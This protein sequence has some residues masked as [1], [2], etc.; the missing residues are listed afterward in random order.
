MSGITITDVKIVGLC[1]KCRKPEDEILKDIHGRVYEDK[2]ISCVGCALGVEKYYIWICTNCGKQLS[3]EIMGKKC[4]HCD[5]W[6][7]NMDCKKQVK[8]FN[9]AN[10][11]QSAPEVKE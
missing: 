5:K 2:E 4:P 6:T 7:Y 9:D 8:L 10:D 1:S 3:E 11:S